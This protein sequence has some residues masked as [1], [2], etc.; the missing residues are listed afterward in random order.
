MKF[1]FA[2]CFRT[3]EHNMA[4]WV[5]EEAESAREAVESVMREFTISEIVGVYKGQQRWKWA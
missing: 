1:K 3:S 2:I 5:T 4:I